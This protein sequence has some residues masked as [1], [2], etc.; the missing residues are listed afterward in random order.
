METSCTRQMHP[1]TGLP[2][3]AQVLHGIGEGVLGV[4]DQDSPL[5]KPLTRDA[6]ACRVITSSDVSLSPYSEEMVPATATEIPAGASRK[7]SA[8][9]MNALGAGEKGPG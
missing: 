6:R 7:L 9:C 3:A 1:T 2:G 4:G 8:H 5:Y